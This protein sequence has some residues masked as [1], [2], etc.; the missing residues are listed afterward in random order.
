MR[1][2][3]F[4][5]ITAILAGCSPRNSSVMSDKGADSAAA[6]KKE[7]LVGADKDS[8]GCKG[9]AG[10]QWSELLQN[11]IRPWEKGIKMVSIEDPT[12]AGYA[13]FSPDST[14][15]ELFLLSGNEILDRRKTATGYSWNIEDDDTKTLIKRDGK[16]SVE[17]RM[18]LI[19]QEN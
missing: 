1:K 12:Y 14:K 15:V 5:A 18:K 10:Y 13:V 2:V 9:S 11:C 8:H 6:A 4:V 19:Y 16:W 17:Q 7:T 3:I